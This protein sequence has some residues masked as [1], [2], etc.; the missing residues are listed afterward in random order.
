MHILDSGMPHHDEVDSPKFSEGGQIIIQED[1]FEVESK[2]LSN[3][4]M[5]GSKDGSSDK[6]IDHSSNTS[7][8]PRERKVSEM[9]EQSPVLHSGNFRKT[10]H[11][12]GQQSVEGA[13]AN[14]SNPFDSPFEHSGSSSSRPSKPRVD[15]FKKFDALPS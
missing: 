10:S 11:L 4:Q 5:F 6:S 13:L 15:P 14:L 1:Y 2:K 9:I 7:G 3:P 8:H 12:I